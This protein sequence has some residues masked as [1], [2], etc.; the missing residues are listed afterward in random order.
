LQILTKPQFLV[1]ILVQKNY[2]ISSTTILIAF[3]AL[4][5]TYHSR[6]SF[7]ILHKFLPCR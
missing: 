3:L 2:K 7:Y 5:S 1:Q 4:E 6:D